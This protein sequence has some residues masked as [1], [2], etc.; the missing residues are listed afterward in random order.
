MRGCGETVGLSC[1]SARALACLRGAELL[2][3]RSEERDLLWTPD[4]SIWAAVSPILFPIVGRL[5]D[6][7]LRVGGRATRMNVHGFA[8]ASRFKLERRGTAAARFT[9]CDCPSSRAIYPF[10]FRLS[11]D[12]E[13]SESALKVAMAITNVDEKHLPYACGLHP[14]FCW[15]FDGGKAEEYRLV[16]ER[17]ERASIPEITPEGLF[18]AATRSSPLEGV[19]LPLTRELFT[20]EALCF[21]DAR[22]RVFRFIAPTGREIRLETSDFPHFALWSRPP[23]PFLCLESWTGY[24]DPADFT[25]D[26]FEKPSMRSLAPGETARH[27]ANYALL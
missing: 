7:L 11:I 6:N 13:L 25:G 18:G 26:V 17:S 10:R 24:G 3:W 4:P 21:L 2:T 8:A 1:G 23:A 16:F 27:E 20:R 19:D 5:R 22:S 12:Y 9:L 14:G 15:P